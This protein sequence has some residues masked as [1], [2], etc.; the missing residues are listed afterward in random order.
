MREIQKQGLSVFLIMAVYVLY[1]GLIL[2]KFTVVLA[3]ELSMFTT[4]RRYQQSA[5]NI[6]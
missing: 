5:Q 3:K 2:V 6:K 1:V 4:L